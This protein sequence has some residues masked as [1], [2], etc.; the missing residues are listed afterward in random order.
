MQARVREVT[1]REILIRSTCNSQL[2]A[3]ADKEEM[4]Q[5]CVGGGERGAV[6]TRTLVCVWV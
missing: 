6:R 3:L 2:Q 4:V 1:D 5:V